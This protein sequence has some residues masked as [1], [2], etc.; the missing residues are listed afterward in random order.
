MSAVSSEFS[1]QAWRSAPLIGPSA[2]RFAFDFS[3]GYTL[4]IVASACANIIAAGIMIG[5]S[6]G[7]TA[8]T[9]SG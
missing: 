4:P 1:T 5:M 6:R 8:T 2:A 7:R 9:R 3:H